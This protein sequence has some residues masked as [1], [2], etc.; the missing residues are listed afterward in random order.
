MLRIIIIVIVCLVLFIVQ[1]NL[2]FIQHIGMNLHKSRPAVVNNVDLS[3]YRNNP[4]QYFSILKEKQNA[5]KN[6]IH[7]SYSHVFGLSEYYKKGDFEKQID[8]SIMPGEKRGLS[9]STIRVGKKEYIVMLNQKGYPPIA[10]KCPLGAKPSNL[11]GYL[12]LL[13]KNPQNMKYLYQ[14]KHRTGNICSVW[15]SR[16]NSKRWNEKLQKFTNFLS[17]S[18]MCVDEK[19]GVNYFSKSSNLTASY[20]VEYAHNVKEIEFDTVKNKDF[21]IPKHVKWIVSLNFLKAAF[22]NSS[23]LVE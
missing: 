15:E 13:P 6:N 5:S 16:E 7:G 19:T 10:I 4:T 21:L 8:Y 23:H 12:F 14:R 20:G 22:G 18:Q 1:P 11:S 2:H 3:K 9:I 17:V